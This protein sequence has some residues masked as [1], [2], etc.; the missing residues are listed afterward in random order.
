MRLLIVKTSSLGDILQTLPAITD[1]TTARPDLTIDW[2]VERAFAAAPAWH[3]QISDVIPIEFRR[4]RRRPDLGEIAQLIRRLRER[5]YDLIID[6]QGLLKSALLMLLA[7]GPA[8]GFD[9]SSAREGVVSLLYGRRAHA[10]WELHAVDRQRRL[11]AQALGYPLPQTAPD[12]GLPRSARPERSRLLM[13]HG[14]TWATKRWPEIYWSE[15][16]NL[17]AAAGIEPVL[18]WHDRAERESAERI[19][20]AAP[21]TRVIPAPN[22]ETLRRVIAESSIVAANDSGPAHLAAALGVPS[23]T[24]YGATRPEHNGTLGPG[25]IHLAADFPCSPC[26]N[27]VCTFR[28]P[29]PVTPACYATLPPARVWQELQQLLE[30]SEPCFTPLPNPPPQGGRGF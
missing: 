3:P 11:F 9:F 20:A 7:R 6:A 8:V 19:A 22:L 30:S 5:R 28:G 13:L 18:R 29:A 2:L 27:R 4:W 17:A 24:L 12:Y 25:Q 10:S 15:L 14:A 16:A 1:A 26:R 21:G 23:V